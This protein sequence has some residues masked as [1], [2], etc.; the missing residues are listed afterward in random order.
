M[1]RPNE[2]SEQSYPLV[3]TL[4]ILSAAFPES[5]GLYNNNEILFIVAPTVTSQAQTPPIPPS[6]IELYK[7]YNNRARAKH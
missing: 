7:Q 1:R 3:K 4:N 5:P 2:W 6:L